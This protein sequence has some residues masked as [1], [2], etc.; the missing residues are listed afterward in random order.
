MSRT[1][2]ILRI[3]REK[4][5]F[6]CVA[7]ATRDEDVVRLLL[8]YIV[9]EVYFNKTYVL[10][11]P[12]SIVSLPSFL[13]ILSS[14]PQL[15]HISLAAAAVACCRAASSRAISLRFALI[16]LSISPF[17]FSVALRASIVSSWVARAATS[18][19][20]SS[21]LCAFAAAFAALTDLACSS[22]ALFARASDASASI[23]SF[24]FSATASD[25]EL[26]VEATVAA[27]ALALSAADSAC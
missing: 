25:C 1:C 10:R 16:T 7:L 2:D 17:V 27:S 22:N 15:P 21:A 12:G 26:N 4:R 5:G 19:F 11:R 18:A 8:R 14:A 13:V 6:V 24:D 23:F 9:L 3:A 20:A